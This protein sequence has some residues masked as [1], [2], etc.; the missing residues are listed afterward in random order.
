MY[1]IDVLEKKKGLLFAEGLITASTLSKVSEVHRRLTREIAP[2]S[3]N[4]TDRYG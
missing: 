2:D 4:I 3:L 1:L